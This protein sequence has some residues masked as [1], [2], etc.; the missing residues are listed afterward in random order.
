MKT[1]AAAYIKLIYG[2]NRFAR[3]I[4]LQDTDSLIDLMDDYANHKASEV[5]KEVLKRAAE[6]AKQ[7]Y[8]EEFAL[9]AIDKN[10]ILNT[11]YGDLI[12]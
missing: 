10:S 6:N 4:V 7:I 12:K 11:P 9:H 2:T 5:A 3:T 8:N 1:T